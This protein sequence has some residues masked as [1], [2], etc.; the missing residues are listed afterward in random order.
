MVRTSATWL[1]FRC[2]VQLCKLHCLMTSAMLLP[3]LPVGPSPSQLQLLN[4]TVQGSIVQ[5]YR[6]FAADGIAYLWPYLGRQRPMGTHG[7]LAADNY[8]SML[9][10]HLPSIHSL[11]HVEHLSGVYAALWPVHQLS[12]SRLLVG[13]PLPEM[14]TSSLGLWSDYSPMT[15]PGAGVCSWPWNMQGFLNTAVTGQLG[16]NDAWSS[17]SFAA[18]AGE[19]FRAAAS[20]PGSSAFKELVHRTSMH[21]TPT[22]LGLLCCFHCRWCLQ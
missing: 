14:P 10:G 2:S 15:W 21:A 9:G 8:C 7:V 6:S 11:G 3:V 22:K 4:I 13:L 20:S 1:P 12:D 5:F 19:L 17:S 16:Y 18:C